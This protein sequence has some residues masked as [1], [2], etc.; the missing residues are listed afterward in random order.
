MY[1][2]AFLL[3]TIAYADNFKI[4]VFYPGGLSIDSM[5]QSSVG[6]IASP[7]FTVSYMPVD[8]STWNNSSSLANFL[9]SKQ[10][11]SP[12]DGFFLACKNI[13]LD[14]ISNQF[15][16]SFPKVPFVDSYAPALMA[17]NIVSYRYIV[18]TGSQAGKTL[19]R[20]LISELGIE[21]HLRFGGSSLFRNSFMISSLPYSL[22]TPKE[23]SIQD[24]VNLGEAVTGS[25]DT[26]LV[27]LNAE[28]IV[29]A[30]CEG[31]LDLGVATASQSQLTAEKIPLQ[32]INPIKASMGLL[33]SMIRNKVWVSVPRPFEESKPQLPEITPTTA[34]IVLN[35]AVGTNVNGP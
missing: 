20:N 3:C 26:D 11:S 27:V 10:Q 17:A 28:A 30:G 7:D 8:S 25:H 12:A 21:N 2:V 32:V 5:L 31:F 23:V 9:V 24:I 1:F 35:R 22:T 14:K 6:S 4:N 16:L 13:D 15:R 34:P 19:T 18:I 33:Y 29:L